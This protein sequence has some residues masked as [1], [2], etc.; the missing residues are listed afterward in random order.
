MYAL[1]IISFILGTW[2]IFT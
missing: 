2:P 1:N